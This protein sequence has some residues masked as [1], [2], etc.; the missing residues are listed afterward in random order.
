[1]VQDLGH[2]CQL[3]K[4][5][6]KSAY[7]IIPIKPCDFELLGFYFD[8]NYYFDKALP[9]GASISCITFERFAR[10]LEF[11][12]E[13]NLTSAKLLHY[14]DDFLGGDRSK[15]T[16]AHALRTFKDTMS[17]LGVPLAEDKTEGP[18]EVLTFLGLELDTNQMCVRIP[19]LKVLEV[20]KKIQECLSNKKTTLKKMQ[21]LIGSLNFCCRAVIVGRPFIRR[22]INSI[23]GL[24][25][26]HHHIRV[27]EDI[28]LDLTMWLH[29][30]KQFNGVSVFHD[31]F[32]VSNEDVQLFSDSAGGKNLGFGVYFQ[33]HWCHAKWPEV[34]HELGITEDITVLELFPILAALY[35]WGYELKNKKI[36]FN[37]DNFAVVHILNKL[38]SKSEMV[39]C[40]V[41]VLTL[42]CLKLNILIKASHVPG[43]QN[44]I[45]DALSR[46]QL[47]RFREL[48]PNADEIPCLVPPFLW[49][50]FSLEP[51][52]LFTLE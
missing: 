15:E 16:C 1:M 35:I 37:C 29:F 4:T 7:R 36:R 34:W 44:N 40:I 21:S 5:D 25:K 12:V 50:I 48:A 33:G 39:M 27:K 17:E 13:R 3:F 19:E 26:P 11:S 43:C 38:T 23:C 45:C 52:S 28:C 42:R 51:E 2:N 20:T 49:H 9:F 24:N 32:W 41:R 14:L 6:I 47:T 8:E 18:T 10:F 30:L 22:L 46:F 31:R